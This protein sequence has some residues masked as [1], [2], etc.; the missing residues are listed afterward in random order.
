MR[1]LYAAVMGDIHTDVLHQVQRSLE[2]RFEAPV[3]RIALAEPE[4]AFDP[5]RGQYGSVPVLRMLTEARPPDAWRLLGI[6]SKDLFIPALTFVFGQAQ[7]EGTTAAISLARLRQEFY[8]MPPDPPLLAARA[9]KEALHE[10]GHT[11]GLIHCPEHECVMALATNI[12]QLD[13]K[14]AEFCPACADELG[15]RLR[16]ESG[17]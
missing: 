16:G 6:T 9:C 11:I 17:E 15:S 1:L 14:S 13:A 8:G 5:R 3:R 2:D 7:L 4:F 12:R 10:I